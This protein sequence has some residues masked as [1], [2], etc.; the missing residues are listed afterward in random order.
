MFSNSRQVVCKI[1]GTLGA[2][3]NDA[4]LERA[5]Q[6]GAPYGRDTAKATAGLAEHFKRVI[7]P[8]A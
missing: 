8:Q 1:A 6:L 3:V 7:F 2:P 5:I 4:E